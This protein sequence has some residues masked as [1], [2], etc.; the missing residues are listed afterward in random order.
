MNTPDGSSKRS[1]FG[2]G[3]GWPDTPVPAKFGYEA[4]PEETKRAIRTFCA[5]IYYGPILT[6]YTL[7]HPNIPYHT[8]EDLTHGFIHKAF[9]LPGKKSILDTYRQEFGKFRTYLRA[10]ARFYALSVFRL[11]ANDSNALPF[12]EI[13]ET[14][15]KK[16]HFEEAEL[17]LDLAA[18][19]QIREKALVDLESLKGERGILARPMRGFILKRPECSAN[20][21]EV[22]AE[23][24][25]S[26]DAL[27]QHCSRLTKLYR[28]KFD[29]ILSPLEPS[30][31]SIEETSNYLHGLL[32]GA[33]DVSDHYTLPLIGLLY[34]SCRDARALEKQQLQAFRPDLVKIVDPV[35]QLAEIIKFHDP[36]KQ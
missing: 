33:L 27:R 15:G 28:Q 35:Q 10:A 24:G 32:D 13:I 7:S 1:A 17:K 3:D 19:R 26:H 9:L 20:L 5:S 22:A 6:Y 11:G 14:L 29:E 30:Q 36:Q 2:Q 18:A 23:I 31:I 21:K 8:P 16:A 34:Q 4:A 25:Y 12:D